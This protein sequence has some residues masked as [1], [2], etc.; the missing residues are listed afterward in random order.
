VLSRLGKAS[1]NSPSNGPPFHLLALIALSGLLFL[2]SVSC[3]AVPPVGSVAS[4]T[5]TSPS[6]T[7]L[8]MPVPSG[9]TVYTDP[10]DQY[11]IAYPAN[12][13]IHGASQAGSTT[14]ISNYDLLAWKPGRWKLDII[15]R[16]NPQNLTARQWADRDVASAP[17]P[18]GCPLTV[19]DTTVT[20]GGEMGLQRYE[21]EC[22]GSG[23]RVLIPH[24]G[25]MFLLIA[26]AQPEFQPILSSML[27][28]I[29]FTK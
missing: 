18:S 17:Q 24:G 7:P 16:P 21:S 26:T 27:A 11:S 23:I 6:S 14:S 5:R 8:A 25:R 3:G 28:S 2:A 12:W 19:S 10:F 22:R 29:V 13:F 4:G 9:Q 1:Q 15:P 20:I